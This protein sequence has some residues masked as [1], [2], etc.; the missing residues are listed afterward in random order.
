MWLV[1]HQ[2]HHNTD[3]SGVTTMTNRQVA[4]SEPT[5]LQNG[6]QPYYL[7]SLHS[8][9][10]IYSHAVAEAGAWLTPWSCF[11]L[12]SPGRPSEGAKNNGGARYM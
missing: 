4:Y 10:D 3:S 2:T 5:V 6:V 8:D 1:G 11:T 7:S 12:H 9:T